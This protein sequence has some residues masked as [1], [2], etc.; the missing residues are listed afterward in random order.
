MVSLVGM[1]RMVSKVSLVSIVS[2]VGVV[3]NQNGTFISSV[4]RNPNQKIYEQ[5]RH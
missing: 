4:K 2:V 3:T 5:S 1:V